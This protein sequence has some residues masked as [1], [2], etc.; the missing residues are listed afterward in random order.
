MKNLLIFLF[1]LFSCGDYCQEN[2]KP[3][4]INGLI[5]NKYIDYNNHATK[6]FIINQNQRIIKLA[7][8]DSYSANFLDYISEGDALFK[9]ANSL[10][11]KVK[12]GREM[13][14]FTFHCNPR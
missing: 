14:D 1:F 10:V 9:E 4:E 2:L 8:F 7:F 6:T 13:R 12:K 5:I 11:F 3:M